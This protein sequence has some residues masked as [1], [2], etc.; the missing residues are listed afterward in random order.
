MD[1]ISD[2]YALQTVPEYVL[3]HTHVINQKTQSPETL[4]NKA[5]QKTTQ[6]HSPEQDNCFL[7]KI[8]PEMHPETGFF[9]E[10]KFLL[11]QEYY[12]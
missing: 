10:K 5:F 8:L 7:K 9:R 4:M 6:N 11:N 12:L 1:C 2:L 3:L